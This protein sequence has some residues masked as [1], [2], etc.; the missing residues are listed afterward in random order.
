MKTTHHRLPHSHLLKPVGESNCA[1]FSFP[2]SFIQ[3]TLIAHLQCP[4]NKH[5]ELEILQKKHVAFMGG[6]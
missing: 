3:Q 4:G 2:A 1:C 5:R 6:S